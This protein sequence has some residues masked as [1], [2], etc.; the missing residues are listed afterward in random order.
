MP[1]IQFWPHTDGPKLA[2]FLR[3]RGFDVPR[4]GYSFARSPLWT[5]FWVRWEGKAGR[6]EA[7]YTAN[8]GQPL[9]LVDDV[10]VPITRAEAVAAGIGY[11]RNYDLGGRTSDE[12]RSLPDG[13]ERPAEGD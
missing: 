11:E 3:G 13:F 8:H 1:Y 9:L 12:Q 2:R 6:H 7:H 10:P 4:R 5:S